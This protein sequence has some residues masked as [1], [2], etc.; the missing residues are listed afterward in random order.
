MT[1]Q[2]KW[3]W[4]QDD[5]PRFTYDKK[6]LE[7]AEH[8][9][10]HRSGLFFGMSDHLDKQE[11]D[12]L[13]VELITSEAEKTSE[14][15]GEL[16]DRESLQSSIRRHF[17]LKTDNRRFGAAEAGIAEM[18]FDLYRDFSTP[19]DDA[20][21]FNWHEKLMNGRRDIEIGEYRLDPEP[22]QIISGPFHKP[23]I[24]FEAPASELV[25]SEMREFMEWFN[26]SEKEIPVLARAGIAHIYFESIHPF[27]DGNGRI[28]RALVY[29]I[30]SQSLGRPAI[31]ALS[32]IIN[33]NKKMYYS[34]LERASRSNE[35][36]DW[37]LYFANVILEALDHTEKMALFL[38]AKAKLFMRL[39]GKI[40]HR[41]EKCLLKMFDA[42]FEGFIGGL[43]AEN[44][45]NITKATRPTATRDLA[46]LVFK[47]ALKKI[48]ERKTTRYFLDI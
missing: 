36:T 9:F 37:L 24:H 29:K 15:E 13:K 47:Q 14:I 41:Q 27:A 3:N 20:T 4:Q 10:L 12:G 44:Y 21:I 11:H 42:G 30:L 5:W 45:I 48:G 8:A 31:F 6:L 32:L 25:K 1:R 38:L 17:G 33:R 46:D 43:S 19:L 34:A 26:H 35:I 22:M 16:L 2:E 23:K 39:Q 18:M 40:N 28:G 7:L